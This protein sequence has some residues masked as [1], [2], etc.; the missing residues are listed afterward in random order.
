MIQKV[1]WTAT[2]AFLSTPLLFADTYA[3]KVKAIDADKK[4]ITIPVDGKDKPFKVVDKVDVQTQVRR[5]KRLT[6]TPL[7]EGLK[8]IKVG[9][10]ATITTEK[11]DGEE[12]VTKIVV[13][14][15]EKK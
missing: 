8:G 11:R 5:G 14:V 7:K 15:P 12:V 1:L 6:V 4:L 3:E 13:L 10:E 9:V 2:F